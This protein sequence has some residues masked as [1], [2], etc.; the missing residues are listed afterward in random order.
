MT[1]DAYESIVWSKS[2]P[3]LCDTQLGAQS[4]RIFPPASGH[5]VPPGAFLLESIK[6]GTM[7]IPAKAQ[8][9]SVGGTHCKYFP[10]EQVLELIMSAG[11]DG[12][13][14]FDDI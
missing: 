10:F 11:K 13:L 9:L 7:N 3:S 5:A 4:T 12:D 2:A 8:L 6:V 1:R 14:V